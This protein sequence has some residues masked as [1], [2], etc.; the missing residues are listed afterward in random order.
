MKM[1]IGLCAAVLALAA[2]ADR[3]GAG[4]SNYEV[5][6]KQGGGAQSIEVQW[7]TLKPI[8]RYQ[9]AQADTAA[10]AASVRPYAQSPQ[11]GIAAASVPG[12]WLR[13]VEDASRVWLVA[14]SSQKRPPDA[15]GLRNEASQR[16]GCLISSVASTGTATVFLLNCR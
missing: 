8:P 10:S 7:Q 13:I 9:V 11:A 6:P 12:A 15:A 14:E 2:C 3:Q 4:F 5:K 16:S 1:M